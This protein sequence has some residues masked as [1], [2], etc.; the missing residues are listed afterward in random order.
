MPCPYETR[1]ARRR[2]R[3]K[4]EES[5]LKTRFCGELGPGD[6]GA[7]VELAGWVQRRRDHGGLIFV[8]L[9]DS[10]GVAQV[11]FNPEW[12]A[13]AHTAADQ[14]R[15]EYVVAVRGEVVA[16]SADAINAR[17]PTGAIEVHA[18]EARILN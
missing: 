6:V 8:D 4:P 13:A 10:Q 1:V 18:S 16:R 9:R 14:M 12:S 5:V 17:M 11:V 3:R 2:A 7:E 15:G